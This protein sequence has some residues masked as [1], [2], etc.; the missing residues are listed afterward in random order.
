MIWISLPAD[1]SIDYF[2]YRLIGLLGFRLG[3]FKIHEQGHE[4]THKA[5]DDAANAIPD[6]IS[7]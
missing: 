4:T 7:E 5:T 3:R 2:I 6:C 1:G